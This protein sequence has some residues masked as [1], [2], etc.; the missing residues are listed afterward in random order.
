ME[1]EGLELIIEFYNTSTQS[2]FSSLFWNFMSS[3][4][5]MH[6]VLGIAGS[7]KA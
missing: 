4:L 1:D 2:L 5:N 6:S 7:I 3:Q